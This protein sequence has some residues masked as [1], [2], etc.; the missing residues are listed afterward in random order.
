MTRLIRLALTAIAGLALPGVVGAAEPYP[1]RP[2]RI[3]VT[4]PPGG[5]TDALARIIQPRLEAELGQ[6]I[7]IENRPGAGGTIGVDAVV[8]SAPDGYVL[9]IGP[10][11]ALTVNLSPQEKIPYDTVRDLEPVSLLSMTPF[12]MAAR[13]GFMANNAAEVIALAKAKPEDLTLGHGGNGSA[14]HLTALL[15]NHMAGVE[16]AL[17]PYR[18]S[19]AVFSDLIAGHIPLGI[20]DATSALGA[21]RAG[22]VKALAVSSAKRTPLLPDIATFAESGLPGFESMGWFGI[23]APAGTPREIIAKLNAAVVSAYKDPA[24]V[25]RLRAIGADPVSS[26]PE[27]FGQFIRSEIV[28]WARVVAQS[29][30]R[31]E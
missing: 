28:K 19:G 18:G 24:L 5:Q 4:F 10:M 13:L 11:G 14:M 23:L 6:P 9:G 15:F 22:Q 17:V 1:V 7:V 16:I 27:E 2:I 31:P 29:G 12:V 3:I 26:T 20:G 25:E 21:I 30:L 8:K